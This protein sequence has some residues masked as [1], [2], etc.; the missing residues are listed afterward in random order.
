MITEDLS[1]K[2]QTVSLETSSARLLEENWID[3]TKEELEKAYAELQERPLTEDNLVKWLTDWDN[4]SGGIGGASAVLGLSRDENCDENLR[5]ER[6]DKF[7]SEIS[8]PC[9]PLEINLQRKLLSSGLTIKGSEVPL[10]RMKFGCSRYSGA[11]TPHRIAES[12]ATSEYVSIASD[13]RLEFKGQETTLDELDSKVSEMSNNERIEA[14]KAKRDLYLSRSSAV[15]SVWNKLLK[16]RQKIALTT[17]HEIKTV[18]SYRD[19]RWSELGRIDYS[20]SDVRTFCQ[21]VHEVITPLATELYQKA[22][23][24]LG[25]PIRPWDLRNNDS[26]GLLPPTPEAEIK[27]FGSIK[28]FKSGVRS[29]LNLI[30][31]KLVNY[32]DLLLNTE[33]NSPLLTNRS[34]F[35][36]GSPGVRAP[37]QYSNELPLRK[38]PI[39]F[40]TIIGTQDDITTFFHEF[41]HALHA[42][43]SRDLPFSFQRDVPL[44][45]CEVASTSL[46]FVHATV[47]PISKGGIYSDEI[48]SR[49][50]KRMLSDVIFFFPY[51]A[52]VTSFQDWVYN[53]ISY[54]P[55]AEECDSKWG[56]LWNQYI[57]GIDFTGEEEYRNK[58]WQ[59]KSHIFDQPFYYVE[60]GICY[61]GALQFKERF[62]HNPSSAMKDYLSALSIGGTSSIPEL[63]KAAGL[64][65]NLESVGIREIF[66]PI[67]NRLRELD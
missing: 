14:W 58:G 8:L 61:L 62:S 66:T 19:I 67:A 50:E 25:R 56:E 49:I 37:Y 1:K 48:C 30:E 5:Q 3:I 22:A 21:G 31:P 46:E 51:M 17:N 7:E 65:F 2:K 18:Q 23:N 55:T 38:L 24:R 43:L 60:Y 26:S 10:E 40:Q 57:P 6:Y 15:D 45:F 11:T 34:L 20:P 35:N 29:L 4:L 16:A 9:E 59:R 27:P 42:L 36:F 52:V 13:Q 28:E 41:G 12:L 33:I 64:R 63:F 47:L 32:F 39:I 44:E 54:I 53:N